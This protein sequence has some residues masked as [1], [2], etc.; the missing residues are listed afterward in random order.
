MR[1]Q[2][3]SDLIRSVSRALRLLEE[4][5]D[6][7]DGVNAKRLASRCGIRL[8]TV[9]HLLRTLR[10]EGYL[11]RLS[12]GDYVLGPAIAELFHD[13]TATLTSPSP[14]RDVLQDL[15]DVT[16]HSAY[17]ARFVRGRIT[18]TQVVEAAQSPVLEDLVVGFC[19]GAH[20]TALGKALL[21]TLSGTDRQRYLRETGLRPFTS[22]TITCSDAL[23]DDLRNG[24]QRGVFTELEQYRHGVGCIAS[25]V[26]RTN[27]EAGWWALGISHRVARVPRLVTPLQQ[28]AQDLAVA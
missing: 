17:L 24:A 28:A 20:A 15:A 5:G 21:S 10:Y 25:L 16:G 26:R 12:T 9:Y 2:P 22:L 8:A 4:V 13:L 19:E 7:P 11:Q 23:V 14:A 27:D 6:H 18:I 3:P 1:S